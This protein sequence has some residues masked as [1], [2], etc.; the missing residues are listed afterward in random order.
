MSSSESDNEEQQS[1]DDHSDDSDH[2]YHAEADNTLPNQRT[3][4]RDPVGR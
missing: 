3:R 4:G 1:A 2:L